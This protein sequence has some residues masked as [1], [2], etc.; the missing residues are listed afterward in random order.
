[1]KSQP[2]KIIKKSLPK[3]RFIIIYDKFYSASPVE[4]SNFSVDMTIAVL[5]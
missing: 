1:M 3:Q 5:V 2:K 4:T